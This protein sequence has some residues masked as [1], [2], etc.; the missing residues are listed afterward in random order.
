M[1]NWKHPALA[2]LYWLIASP[3]LIH[4]DLIPKPDFF[5]DLAQSSMS[6]FIDWDESGALTY[7]KI[8]RKRRK[9]LGQYAEDLLKFFFENHPDYHLLGHGIQIKKDKITLGELDFVVEDLIQNKVIHIELSTKFYLMHEQDKGLYGFLGSNPKDRLGDKWSKIL[10]HQI[11]MGQDNLD[12]VPGLNGRP[13]ESEIWLKGRLFYPP[14][15]NEAEGIE[16]LDPNHEKG[17]WMHEKE[18]A[19]ISFEN[20]SPVHKLGWLSGHESE[21]KIWDPVPYGGVLWKGLGE[22]EWVFL[23]NDDWPKPR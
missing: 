14:G 1:R 5:R 16:D 19:S 22:D 9:R 6:L 10:N 12:Q 23:V 20:L 8:P 7:S 4:H 2:D 18:K 21:R 15:L 13:L 11:L 17:L 3:C